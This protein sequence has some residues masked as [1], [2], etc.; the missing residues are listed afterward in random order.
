MNGTKEFGSIELAER[1][2]RVNARLCR[3][4]NRLDSDQAM[5]ASQRWDRI[6]TL[7]ENLADME[8]RRCGE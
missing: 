8:E 5:A 7:L 1:M 6:I 2:N 4:V 3:A